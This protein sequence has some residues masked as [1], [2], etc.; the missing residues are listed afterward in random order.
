MQMEADLFSQ[1]VMLPEAFRT[2]L[3][4]YELSLI[5]KFNQVL[6]TMF[7]PLRKMPYKTRAWAVRAGVQEAFDAESD[8]VPFPPPRGRSCGQ[9]R[10]RGRLARQAEEPTFEEEPANLVAEIR[11]VH[12]TLNTLMKLLV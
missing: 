12:Q 10:G 7:I 4:A 2:D 3:Y 8:R 6:I 1:S 5:L 11:G 9:G